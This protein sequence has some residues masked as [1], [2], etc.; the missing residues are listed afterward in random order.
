MTLKQYELSVFQDRTR[1]VEFMA[2]LVADM[3]QEDPSKRPMIDEVI[4]RFEDACVAIS[5][6]HLRSRFKRSNETKSV[7]RKRDAK[8]FITKTIPYILH[9]RSALPVPPVHSQAA[10]YV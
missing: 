3:I 10:A 9:G 2:P 5:P 8:R 7:R 1:G 4:K 6:W